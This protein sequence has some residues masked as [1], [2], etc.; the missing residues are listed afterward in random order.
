MSDPLAISGQG[1]FFTGLREHTG[2]AGTGIYGMHAGW[3]SP[4]SVRGN[5]VL[6]HGGGGQ[7]LDMLATPD[8]REGW[9]TLFLRAGFRSTR[10]G[11]G[12]AHGTIPR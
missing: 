10:S 2:P 8:G 5:L 9:A 1:H 6:V 11:Q 7:A 3:Q 12:T 4:L